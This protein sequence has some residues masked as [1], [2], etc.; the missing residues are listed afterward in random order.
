MPFKSEKQRRYLFANEPEIAKKW[1]KEYNMGG[2]AS[3]FR[4]K[5]ADGDDPFY[6]A[7]KKVYETNPDAASMNEKHDEYLEKY[8][9]EMSTQTSEAPTEDVEQTADPMLN[10]FSET[11]ALNNDQALTT[12][13]AKEEPQGIMTAANGG[14]A[15]K[16]IKGQDHMLAYI[17]PKE[18]DKLV[19]LG[20]QETMTA[21]GIPAYPEWD[22]MYG[23]SSKASFDQGKAPKGTWGGGGNNNNNPNP[24]KGPT[25]AEIAAAKAKAEAEKRR[26]ETEARQKHLKDFKKTQKKKSSWVNKNWEDLRAL[27]TVPYNLAKGLFGNIENPG[28]VT[29]VTLTDAM[30]EHLTNKAINKGTSKGTITNTDYNMPTNTF[31]FNK[32]I[33]PMDIALSST[34]G[35]GNFTTDKTGNINFTGGDYD[36]DGKFGAVGEFIDQ[37]GLMGASKKLGEKI[38]DW[39]AAEGGIANH[40]KFK[41]GGNATKNIKGQ[42]HM[43][44][45]ITPKEAN[46]LVALGGQE[47][48]TP[49]GIPAYPEFD[50]YTESSLAGTSSA[51]SGMSRS[52]FEGSSSG[53]NS[54][55]DQ[56][57]DVAQM[58]SDMGVTTNNAPDYTGSDYGF[59]V[60]EDDQTQLGGSD[61]IGPK[62]RIRINQDIINR[63]NKYD[64]FTQSAIRGVK[65]VGSFMSISN[66]FSF[67][68]FVYDQNKKKN[69]RIQEINADL[70]LL[71]KIEATKYTPHTDTI[72]Q[73]L[74]QEKL[75][76]TQPRSRDD[77]NDND[78]PEE[79]I[80]PI[81]VINEINEV[82]KI[83]PNPCP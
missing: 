70:A 74:E 32:F 52:E 56:E 28:E 62:D 61:Y 30:K 40:F 50:N 39:T 29:Q 68:K 73:M 2:V 34:F 51:G 69:E 41:N 7:W 22:S 57:D 26:L 46:K 27:G 81:P 23:A 36:F 18:A 77:N 63:K 4:K 48:M 1:S 53:N 15:M 6:D 72:Y 49:E 37:G 24:H 38:Y 20:G 19:A 43:L 9:L 8:T 17:T 31:E 65:T 47:T 33:D 64:S 58:E 82:Q 35:Q 71:D 75:D 13:F 10:L 11:D 66:P 80:A 44:A 5:L 12:L 78:G 60:S 55:G 67:A 16:N 25:L 76:L 83:Y 21:E 54:G 79:I 3:M 14:K 45:Y 59:V 42:P